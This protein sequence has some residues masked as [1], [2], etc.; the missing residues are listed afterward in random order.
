MSKKKNLVLFS[1]GKDSLFSTCLTIEEGNHASL[2]TYNNGHLR[3]PENVKHGVGR[4]LKRYGNKSAEFLGV[5]DVRE[6]WWDL[7]SPIYHMTPSKIAEHG[8]ATYNQLQCLTCRTSMYVDAITRCKQLGI[9][10]VVDGARE[11]QGFVNQSEPMVQRYR[12]MFKEYGIDW[13]TPVWDLKDDWKLKNDLLSRDITPK[14]LEPMCVV[15][16]PLDQVPEPDDVIQGTV[17]LFDKYV[18]P[19]IP[20]LVEKN[21]NKPLVNT[22]K[23]VRLSIGIDL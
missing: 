11:S 8:G 15:G 1:G 9:D 13:Q 16:Y 3:E 5:V 6:I 21:K 23:N 2:I 19:E 10:T 22:V 4:I 14:T 20:R 12:E 18:L 7:R 17:N